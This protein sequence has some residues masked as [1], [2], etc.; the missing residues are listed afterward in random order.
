MARIRNASENK[1]T[2]TT[3]NRSESYKEI[4]SNTEIFVKVGMYE[5]ADDGSQVFTSLPGIIPLNTALARDDWSQGQGQDLI[6]NGN[7]MQEDL[8]EYAEKLL[9]GE[10]VDVQ[11]LVVRIFRKKSRQKE[12]H[13]KRSYSF[14]F[15]KNTN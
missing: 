5:E 4:F 8:I 13:K 12:F 6:L 2:A 1:S 15:V 11:D 14:N 7:D 10:E 9:P 3:F